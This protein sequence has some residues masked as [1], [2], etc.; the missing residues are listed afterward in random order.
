M[1]VALAALAVAALSVV[2]FAPIVRYVIRQSA[3]D[4]ELLVNQLCA[5]A[6]RPWQEPPAWTHPEPLDENLLVTSPEQLPDEYAY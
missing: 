6:G 2:C 1:Y 3:R 4:R 5:L